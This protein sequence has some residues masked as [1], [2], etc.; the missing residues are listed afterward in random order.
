MTFLLCTL[1]ANARCL[2]GGAHLLIRPSPSLVS[3]VRVPCIRSPPARNERAVPWHGPEPDPDHGPGPAPTLILRS[4]PVL[5]LSRTNPSVGR[6]A[7]PVPV[8]VSV[9][10]CR[11]AD[12]QTVRLICSRAFFLSHVS[13]YMTKM[14]ID[15]S[16]LSPPVAL[17]G[18]QI[19]TEMDMGTNKDGTGR[20][21]TSTP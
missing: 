21:C 16:V 14:K 1:Y 18:S 5:H 11:R 10:I 6:H 20:T 12:V 13:S 15:T 4:N 19:K 9:L 7:E 2:R 17:G 3:S 8:P